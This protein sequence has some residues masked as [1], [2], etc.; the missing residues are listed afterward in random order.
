M[1]VLEEVSII[2]IC[3]TSFQEDAIESARCLLELEVVPERRVRRKG[4]GKTTMSLQDIIKTMKESAPDQLPIQRS[5]Q[6]ATSYF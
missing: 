2:Q 4:V 5:Q 3:S 1:D 6:I